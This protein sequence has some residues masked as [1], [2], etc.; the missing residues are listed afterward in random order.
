MKN[1]ST[2]KK[3]WLNEALSPEL[4]ALA[5]PKLPALVICSSGS[6]YPSYV[7]YPNWWRLYGGN[8]GNQKPRIYVIAIYFFSPYINTVNLVYT[9]LV[10][11]I[12]V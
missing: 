6:L 8:R 9:S 7:F 1:T 2:F 12:L 4:G 10:H 3:L 11:T 5:N